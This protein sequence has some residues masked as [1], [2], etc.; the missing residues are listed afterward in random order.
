MRL[1]S[2]SEDPLLGAFAVVGVMSGRDF[3]KV[4]SSSV[5]LLLSGTNGQVSAQMEPCP[6][7][8]LMEFWGLY[9]LD[10]MG[11]PRPTGFSSQKGGSAGFFS[12]RK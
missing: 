10:R 3:G 1:S 6:L 7:L 8:V 12:C 5:F 11:K 4:V 2:A 9:E